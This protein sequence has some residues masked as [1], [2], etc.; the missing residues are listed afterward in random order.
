MSRRIVLVATAWL[1]AAALTAT[2]ATAAVNAVGSGLLGQGSPVLSQDEVRGRLS[3]TPQLATPGAGAPTGSPS[4]AVPSPSGDT[5][6]PSATRVL[7]TGGG[8]VVARCAAGQVTLVSWSPAQGYRTDD[9][10]RGP[11]EAASVKFKSSDVE[12]TVTVTCAGDEP[13]AA[14][15]TDHRHGG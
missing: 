14:T 7:A 4:A 9:V 12:L 13:Q 3:A 11:A 1:F 10:N 15:A 8:T 6:S 2:A 5:A